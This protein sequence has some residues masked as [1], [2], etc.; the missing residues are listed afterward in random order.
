MSVKSCT[1][2]HFKKQTSNANLSK[3]KIFENVDR[4]IEN[5]H[6]TDPE[7]KK[8]HTSTH[9]TPEQHPQVTTEA[10]AL[11]VLDAE[12]TEIQQSTTHPLVT[13]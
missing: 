10:Q 4:Y 1:I 9:S 2:A 7:I 13:E 12:F 3:V 5:N 8:C 6:S 11:T